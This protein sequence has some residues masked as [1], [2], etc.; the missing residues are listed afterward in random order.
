MNI[1]IVDDEA[2]IRKGLER[3][4]GQFDGFRV[5]GTADD[6]E[7]ALEWL[8]SAD[9]PPDL[10]ITDIFMQYIDGLEFIERVSGQYP[11]IRCAI[12]SGHGEFHLAQKAIDLKVCRYITKPVEPPELF[13]VLDGIREEIRKERTRYADPLRMEQLTANATLYVRDKLLSDLLEGRLV[14]ASELRDFAGC[15]PFS[16]DAHFVGGVVRVCKYG[17][18]LSQRDMLLYSVAVKQLFTEVVLS[19]TA[20]FVMIKETGTLV[21]GTRGAQPDWEA[22]DSF[23]SLAESVLGIPIAFETGE[24]AHG[25]LEL[26]PSLAGAVDR[27]ESR[28]NEHFFFPLEQVQQ[29][30]LAARAGDIEEMRVAAHA[31]IHTLLE[32]NFG[33]ELVL[34]G[35]YKLIESMEGLLG[36]LDIECPKPPQLLHLPLPSVVDY[37]EK[38]LDSCISLCGRLKPRPGSDMV[39]KVMVHMEENYADHSLSLNSLAERV[40]VHPNYLT[41]MFRKQTGL[42]CMQ[43]L[44]RLRMEKAKLLL[45]EPDLKI[46]EIADR[47]GYGNPLYFSSYFKKWVGVNPTDYKDGLGTYA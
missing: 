9:A 1:L 13:S 33:M 24:T 16:L 10:I 12:L 41:H 26:Q 36:Q 23:G 2:I 20:G 31:F 38:W 39:H 21:F 3:A 30:R 7:S 32:H 27:L 6:G 18:D 17:M 37:M 47:V 15:F 45:H 29:L 4:I 35:F 44:A 25:L 8:K 46:C 19:G 11:H 42:S 14:S 22:L 28:I 5:V 43:F 40:S 34:Q